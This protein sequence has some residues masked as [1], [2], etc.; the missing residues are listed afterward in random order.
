M[1]REDTIASYLPEGFSVD[2]YSPG[3]GVTR[4]RF[5]SE[6]AANYFSGNGVFTALGFKE[7]IAFARGLSVGYHNAKQ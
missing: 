3:D 1:T 7:A 4:Y 6:N 5:F 2:T